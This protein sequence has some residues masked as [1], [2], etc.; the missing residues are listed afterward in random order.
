[1]T[2]ASDECVALLRTYIAEVNLQ[3]GRLDRKS[4]W[5]ESDKVQLLKEKRIWLRKLR[6][7]GANLQLVADTTEND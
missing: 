6:E 4:K 2:A 1:M 7:Y 3:L 5:Y